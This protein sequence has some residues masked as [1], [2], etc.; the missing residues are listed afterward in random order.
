MQVGLGSPLHG[1][2]WLL[3]WRL[4]RPRPWGGCVHGGDEQQHHQQ[5]SSQEQVDVRH[6]E[7]GSGVNGYSLSPL[8]CFWLSSPAKEQI[9]LAD[10]SRQ[11]RAME[12]RRKSRNQFALAALL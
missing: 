3:H 11:R 5:L 6:G 9:A 7:M 8:A 1:Q 10:Q 4:R 12:R 2:P